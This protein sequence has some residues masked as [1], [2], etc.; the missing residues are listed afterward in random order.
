MEKLEALYERVC[1]LDVHKKSVV[2]C[3]RRITSSGRIEKEVATFGTTTSQVLALLGW[4][5][6]WDVTHVAMESTGVYWQPVWNLLEG[7]V[8]LLLVNARHLKTVPGRKT[9]V[10]DAEWIAQLLQYGLLRGSFVPSLDVRQ[11]RDLTRHRS[12]LM[13]Q[14]PSVVNRLHTVLEDAKVKLSSVISDLMGVSGLRMLRAMV[15]GETAAE[16][17]SQLGDPKLRASQDAVQESLQGKLTE[18]HRFMLEGL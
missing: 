8:E 3:R 13:G 9:D 10:K 7:H 11:W 2:A 17:L 5:Q 6:E 15:E 4:L 12:K 1:G 16:V 18:Q 14:R